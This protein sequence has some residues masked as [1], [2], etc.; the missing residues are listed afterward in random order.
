MLDHLFAS[1]GTESATDSLTAWPAALTERERDVLL[2][3]VPRGG[4][5]TVRWWV[6]GSGG[7]DLPRN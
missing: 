3:V 7:C 1:G 2:L 4:L 5:E 6:T